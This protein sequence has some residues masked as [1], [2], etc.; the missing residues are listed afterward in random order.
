MIDTVEIHTRNVPRDKWLE[1]KAEAARRE[2]EL[3]PMLG[4]MIKAWMDAKNAGDGA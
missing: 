3:G 2:L 1:L 4:E